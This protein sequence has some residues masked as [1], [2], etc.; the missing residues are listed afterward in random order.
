MDD[1]PRE[2]QLNI[3]LDPEHLAGA[4]ANFANVTFSPYEFT[5][6]F[7]RIEHEVEDGD[8]PGSVVSRVNM[9]SRF[10]RE[11]LDAM[12]DAWSKWSTTEGIRNLPEI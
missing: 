10:M 6:T 11:L 3:H 8:V 5:I 9:S 1:E 7:A 4:Y 12:E 2:R